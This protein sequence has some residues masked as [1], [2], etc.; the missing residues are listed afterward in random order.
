MYVSQFPISKFSAAE[1]SFREPNFVTI[2]FKELVVAFL[3]EAT[4]RKKFPLKLLF[5]DCA[6]VFYDVTILLDFYNIAFML[7]STKKQFLVH[8]L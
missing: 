6:A 2:F 1:N 8:K 3:P 7:S 5:R 4:H